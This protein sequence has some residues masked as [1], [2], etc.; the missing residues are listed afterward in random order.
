MHLIQAALAAP[1][2]SHAYD[3]VLGAVGSVLMILL[4][5]LIRVINKMSEGFKQRMDQL[6]AT[7]NELYFVV[8]GNPKVDGDKG[9]AGK[10]NGHSTVIENHED[11]LRDLEQ[12]PHRPW[13]DP[14]MPGQKR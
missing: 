14:S 3:I 11:R 1:V 6:A 7:L 12:Q 9:L 10:I 8:C 13:Y 4:G 2:P 5:A